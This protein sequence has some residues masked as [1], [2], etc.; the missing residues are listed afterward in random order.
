LDLSGSVTSSRLLWTREWTYGFHKRRGI[1]LLSRRLLSQGLFLTELVVWDMEFSRLWIV[2]LWSGIWQVP[3][4][5]RTCCTHL[6]GRKVKYSTYWKMFRIRIVLVIRSNFLAAVFCK[7][8]ILL[9]LFFI[10]LQLVPWSRKC[11]SIHPL[12]HTSSWRNA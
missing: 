11:G 2:R 5:R 6:R 12:P 7:I 3:T 9:K 10:K 1:S 8:I 4:F